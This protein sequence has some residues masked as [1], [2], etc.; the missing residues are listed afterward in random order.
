MS[1]TAVLNRPGPWGRAWRRTYEAGYG[2]FRALVMLLL[3]PLFRVRRRGAEPPWPPG[4]FLLCANHTSYLDP[5][6]V[7]L[8]VPRRV[9]F[10]MTNDWYVRPGGRWFFALVGAVPMGRGRL[11]RAGLAR[12][13]ALVRRGHAV[14]LFPEGRIS[15]DGR[16]GEPQ[17]GVGRLA[18]LCRAPVLPVGIRG[19][20]RTLPPGSRWFRCGD[21]QVEFGSPLAWEGPRTDSH[22]AGC[23][24]RERAF[25]L[26]LMQR[27]RSLAGFPPDPPDLG[28][29]S[30]PP[31]GPRG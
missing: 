31:T 4:G 24:E 2:A 18:R 20:S 16:P 7:Q 12:A 22:G 11:G 30:A 27:I 29:S 15:L 26:T 10:V 1:L 28:P 14:V 6:F 19:A 8:T 9:T 3:R 23:K 21:V 13:A 5:A 17:R 25:A